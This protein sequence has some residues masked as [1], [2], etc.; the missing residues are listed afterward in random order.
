MTAPAPMTGDPASRKPRDDEIDVHGLTHRGKLREVNEDH[1]L[2]AS[3]H[4]KVQ[5]HMTSLPSSQ[6]FGDTERLAFLAMVADGVGGGPHGSDASRWALEGVTHYVTHSLQCYYSSNTADETAFLAGLEDAALHCHS[7]LQQRAE[8]DPAHEGMASTLT[9]WLGVWPRAYLL[10]VGDS[11]AYLLRDERLAQL[12]RDQ[13][14]AQVL[15]DQG[16][17]TRVDAAGTRWEHVLSSSIGGPESV[18]VVT[19][20]DQQWGDVGL[21]CSDGLTKHVPDERIRERLLAMPS[22]REGCEALLQDALDAGGTDNI[23]IIIGR[24]AKRP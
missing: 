24:T 23:T 4:K 6:E 3:L 7:E 10:Q 19:R 17:L 11:R 18:P 5:V 22:A 21:L 2:I 9:L 15:I 16:I 13:T 12:S 8:D 20:F 14:M 1:F